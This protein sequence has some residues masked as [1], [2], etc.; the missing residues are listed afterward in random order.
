M[1]A[2]EATGSRPAGDRRQAKALR[3][4]EALAEAAVE[5]V[6]ERGLAEV[7]VEAIAERADVTRRTFS[8]HF[9]GKEDAALDFTRADGAGS[10]SSSLGWMRM[11]SVIVAARLPESKGVGW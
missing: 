2:N 3:T 9:A 10:W 1:K 4:R 7:T 5:L 6:L 11:G 8:R